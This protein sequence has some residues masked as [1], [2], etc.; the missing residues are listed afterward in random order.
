M[1]YSS[2]KQKKRVDRIGG[3]SFDLQRGKNRACVGK[4]KVT[5][6]LQCKKEVNATASGL[7]LYQITYYISRK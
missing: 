3:T 2:S 4:K 6:D 1:A 5:L 7:I